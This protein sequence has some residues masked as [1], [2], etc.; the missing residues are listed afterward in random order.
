MATK[1]QCE[2]AEQEGREAAERG[3]RGTA[4]YDDPDRGWSWITGWELRMAEIDMA[5]LK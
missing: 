1:K 4:P 3:E 2:K 5:N